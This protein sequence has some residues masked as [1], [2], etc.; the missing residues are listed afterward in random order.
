MFV[1]DTSINNDSQVFALA[2][3]NDNKLVASGDFNGWIKIWDIVKT[4][5]W[6]D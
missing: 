1:C 6:L 5:R 2:L 3:S 4:S